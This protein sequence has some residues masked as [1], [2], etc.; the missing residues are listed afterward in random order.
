MVDSGGLLSRSLS[1][2][3]SLVWGGGGAA[4]RYAG[5]VMKLGWGS[6]IKKV[7]V[8]KTPS[9]RYMLDI[10]PDDNPEDAGLQRTLSSRI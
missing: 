8:H 4:C 2:E 9:E 1:R 3:E 10:F 6:S 5:L 7:A